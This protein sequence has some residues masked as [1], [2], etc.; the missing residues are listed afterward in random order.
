MRVFNYVPTTFLLGETILLLSAC[1]HSQ[2]PHSCNL[3]KL[4]DAYNAIDSASILIVAS[5][6][7][8]W[9]I[10]HT[11]ARRLTTFSYS[12]GRLTKLH[13]FQRLAVLQRLPSALSANQCFTWRLPKQTIIIISPLYCTKPHIAPHL[14]TDTIL[15]ASCQSISTSSPQI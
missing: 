8:L 11:F 2:I 4:H 12:Y 13:I 1:L 6:F 7:H 10:G 9:Y 3:S 15:N 5:S 14:D